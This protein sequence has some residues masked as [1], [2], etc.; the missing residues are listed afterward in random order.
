MQKS[1]VL[2][3]IARRTR[4]ILARC[5]SEEAIKFGNAL[6]ITMYQGHHID[7]MIAKVAR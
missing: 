6:G 5:D 7:R 3:L 2:V 4:I 1:A